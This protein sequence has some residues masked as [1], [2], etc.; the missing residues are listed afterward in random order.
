MHRSLS[1]HVLVCYV[2]VAVTSI[3]GTVGAF[4]IIYPPDIAGRTFPSPRYLICCYFVLLILII[5][6]LH[7]GLDICELAHNTG[8]QS[9]A[10]LSIS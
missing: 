5:D 4:E 9:L 2:L 1:A 3:V 7:F 10:S 8:P 6:S